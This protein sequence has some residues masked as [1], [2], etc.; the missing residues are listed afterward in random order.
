M[1]RVQNIL[2]GKIEEF[3]KESLFEFMRDTRVP[4]QQ[5]LAFVPALAHF[6]MSFADLYALVLRR[7]PAE[8]EHQELVN[9]HTYEDGG[10]WKWFLADLGNL[11]C[12]PVVKYSDAIRFIWGSSTVHMRRLTYGLCQLCHESD[13]LRRLVLVQCIEAAGKVSLASSAVVA[14]EIAAAT[15]KSLVYFGPHH[16]ETESD[17]ALEEE[18]VHAEL[19]RLQ[20]DDARV[21]EFT[22]VI[23]QSF[24]LF[25]EFIRELRETCRRDVNGPRARP[26]LE[27]QVED[28]EAG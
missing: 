20:L 27:A 19:A 18:R 12:D 24:E 21:E 25:T 7:E 26:G 6:V 22:A 4:A 8:D 28:A 1:Q 16:F 2:N 15:K 10:H 14:Q 23:E 3:E 17:H 11:G 9:A 5:R 13:S